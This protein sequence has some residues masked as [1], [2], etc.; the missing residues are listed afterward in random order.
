M[1]LLKVKYTYIYTILLSESMAELVISKHLDVKRFIERE[2]RE[3]RK[4]QKEISRLISIFPEKITFY[5]RHHSPRGEESTT[6]PSKVQKKKVEL[7]GQHR[8]EGEKKKK[9]KSGTTEIHTITSITSIKQYP[10]LSIFMLLFLL[11]LN[12]ADS[13]F[14]LLVIVHFAVC[15]TVKKREKEEKEEK[16]ERDKKKFPD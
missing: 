16:G 4:R 10:L 8:E 12:T 6:I 9:K 2:R 11:S 7:P 3:R 14:P 1:F 13:P 5:L 15:R